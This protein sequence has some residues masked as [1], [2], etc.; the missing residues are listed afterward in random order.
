[1]PEI[2]LSYAVKLPPELA[3]K[4]FRSKGYAISFDWHE[5][6]NE[7]HTKA[8]TVAKAM[9]IDILQDIRAA[10]DK[11]LHDGSTLQQF[12]KELTPILQ[13][14]G[15][16]GRQ[17]ILNEATGELRMAQLGSPRRLQTIY[18]ANLQT[19]Y[20]AGRYQSMMGNVKDRPY[21]QYIAVM[22]GRTRPAHRALHG[23]I[24][25][26]DDPI[27]QY[28]YPP[29]GFR[30][31]CR[32]RARS[33]AEVEAMGLKVESSAGKLDFVDMPLGNDG[34]MT[35][36]ARYRGL[37]AMGRPFT[38]SPDAGWSY[39]PGADSGQHLEG[40]LQQK[41]AGLPPGIRTAVESETP[42]FIR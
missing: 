40:I 30:C 11:A 13:A 23:K 32:V 17:E 2:D 3:V 18:Q 25:R 12:Q 1:M 39:N 15:W 31:R 37:D 20:M 27:W 29:N 19:A 16:W 22:D 26:F 28:I 24:F 14:K 4:Y 8:F 10:V 36:V 35:P 21:W 5:M 38:F 33:A 9:R 34:D 42:A 6:L 41:V 7:A